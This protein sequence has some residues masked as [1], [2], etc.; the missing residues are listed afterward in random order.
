MREFLAASMVIP[1]LMAL[2]LISKSLLV[3]DT[4]KRPLVKVMVF[5]GKLFAKVMVSV[6]EALPSA[7][8]LL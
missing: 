5:D 3:G 6:P 1:P 2:A 7:Q 4:N 8:S